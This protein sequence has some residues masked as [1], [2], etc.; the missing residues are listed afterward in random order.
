MREGANMSQKDYKSKSDKIFIR[1]DL[2]GKIA[3]NFE[4]LKEKWGI[5]NNTE[6]CR[7]LIVREYERSFGKE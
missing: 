2:D 7:L 6:L 4:K 5:K 3:E 1:L